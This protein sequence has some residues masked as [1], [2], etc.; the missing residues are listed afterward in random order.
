MAVTVNDQLGAL[1]PDAIVRGRNTLHRFHLH[2]ATAADAVTPVNMTAVKSVTSDAINWERAEK[3]FQ[4]GGGDEPMFH[5]SGQSHN[6]Q[7]TLYAGM[8]PTFLASLMNFANWGSTGYAAIGLAF[9]RLARFT[10]E[11]IFRKTDNKTHRFSV[12]HQD[13]V[14][15][16]FPLDSPMEDVEVTIPAVS[17]HD[18][19]ILAPG[20]EA[21][22]SVFSGDGSTVAFTLPYT[23]ASLRDLAVGNADDWVLDKMIFVKSKA[24]ADLQGTRLKSGISLVGTALTYATAP[25]VG[26][27]VEALGVKATA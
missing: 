22:Y 7:I 1:S 23:P 17:Y 25:A 27:R 3:Y 6:I 5:N 19:V 10:I 24:T 8:A 15:Q 4:Q 20:Y 18:P 11:S 13:C 26:T 12:I 9:D 16:E 21:V 2:A 14:I